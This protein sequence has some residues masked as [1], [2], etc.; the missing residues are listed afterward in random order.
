[1]SDVEPESARPAPRDPDVSIGQWNAVFVEAATPAT[2][3]APGESAVA[4]GVGTA[5]PEQPA[6]DRALF[7][8]AALLIVEASYSRLGSPAPSSLDYRLLLALAGLVLALVGL[9]VCLRHWSVRRLVRR[10]PHPI[11][12]GLIAFWGGLSYA[13]LYAIALV[14]PI[15]LELEDALLMAIVGSVC[16]LL[17]LGWHVERRAF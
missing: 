2:A 3:S 6:V 13:T 16:L 5:S 15:P 8:V 4:P 1:M 10:T 12:Y 17:V 14:T 11:W 7:G 9:L